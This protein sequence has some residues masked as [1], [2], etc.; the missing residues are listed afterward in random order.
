MVFLLDTFDTE[1]GARDTVR[2][3][4]EL[5]REGIRVQG[6][7]LDS[8]DLAAHARA[9]RT[10]LDDGGLADVSIVVS[11]GLDEYELAR[12]A[13]TGAPIDAFGVGTAL[14]V[15]A[16]AP[17]LECAYKL[18]EYAGRPTRK[19]SQAKASWPGRKQVF[20]TLDAAGRIDRDVITLD[21]DEQ[22]G[23]PLLVP[24]MCAGRRLEPA[25]SLQEIR[26]H[27]ATQL[28]QLPERLKSLQP[29]D[30]L[31]VEIAPALRALGA[32]SRCPGR[33]GASGVACAAGH[34]AGNSDVHCGQRV[35]AAGMLDAQ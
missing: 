30:P 23:M 6:V 5:A 1:E 31:R 25:T 11:G 21:G 15:S 14:D 22:P 24:V 3:A 2:V 7:R 33:Q 9:V 10:I 34:A 27:V 26:R 18:V 20:R 12:L 29:A 19:R 16:D 13:S 4:K 35:A 8:G 32:A 17:Y 28:A